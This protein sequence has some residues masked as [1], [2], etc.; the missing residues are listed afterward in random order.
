VFGL[1]RHGLNDLAVCLSQFLWFQDSPRTTF[2]DATSAKSKQTVQY[3]NLPPVIRPV[4]HSEE[5]PV[6]TPPTNVTVS[7]SESSHERLG[8]A[9]NNV[10]CD[11]TFAGVPSSN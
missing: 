1:S 9:T 8:Q 7:E 2:Q 5:P 11:P 4:P 3:P 10:D 6:P